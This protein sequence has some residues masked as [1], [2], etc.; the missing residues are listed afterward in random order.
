M[1]RKWLRECGDIIKNLTL[2]FLK[3]KMSQE[4]SGSRRESPDIAEV[5]GDDDVGHIP[6][7]PLIRP[8]DVKISD[9]LAK[10]MAGDVRQVQLHRVLG[11]AADIDN[12]R[13]VAEHIQ[14]VFDVLIENCRNQALEKFEEVSFLIRNGKDLSQFLKVDHTRSYIEQAKDLEA[15]IKKT[16]PLFVKPKP[17]GDDEEPAETPPVCSIQDLLSDEML[18]NAAGIGF[19][20]EEVYLLQKSLQRLA[21]KETCSFIRFFGKIRGTD[22]DYYV[23]EATAEGGDPVEPEDGE[24]G[25]E[26]EEKDPDQEDRGAGVNKYAYFVSNGPFSPWTRLPDIGPT[27]I[28]AARKV[29]VLFSGDLERN[30]VCNPFFFGKEKH[31]LRA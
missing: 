31:L 12:E 20:Q 23:V 28:G 18:F 1:K 27:H 24:D 13:T 21:T 26:K 30:I 2:Q 9:K 25:K 16:V 22:A 19:G 11:S 8:E 7:N 5:P 4:E 6:K 14:K 3:F 10:L 29:K 15:Y 17:E